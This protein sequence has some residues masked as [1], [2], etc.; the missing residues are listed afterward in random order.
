MYL[1]HSISIY[2]PWTVNNCWL[3]RLQLPLPGCDFQ[4]VSQQD[5]L[6]LRVRI[7]DSDKLI[8]KFMVNIWSIYGQYMVNIW[9]IYG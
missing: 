2:V 4:G 1:Y 6:D 7:R 5:P 3:G 9:L 8:Q